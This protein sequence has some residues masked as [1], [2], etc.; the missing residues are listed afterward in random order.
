MGTGAM[1][2]HHVQ[3]LEA[4]L[5]RRDQII[6]ELEKQLEYSVLALAHAQA[7]IHHLHAADRGI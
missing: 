3:S 6:S 1:H 2:L 7:R 5:A 4:A